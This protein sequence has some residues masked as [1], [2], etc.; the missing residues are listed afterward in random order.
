MLMESIAKNLEMIS[1]SQKG[2]TDILQAQGISKICGMLEHSKSTLVIQRSVAV[3]AAC[4][5]DTG[6]DQAVRKASGLKV[7]S[8]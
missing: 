1:S 5:Q 6:V 3:L 2:R 7:L 8:E 4:A